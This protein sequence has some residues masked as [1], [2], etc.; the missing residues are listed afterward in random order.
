VRVRFGIAIAWLVAG[1][2]AACAP[3]LAAPAPGTA[4]VVGTVRLV[5]HEGAPSHPE[6][7]GGAYG[8]RRL[9]DVQ[10]VDYSKPGTSVVYL[11]LGTRPGGRA[12]IAV[13]DSVAGARFEPRF[14]VVGAGGEL[15]V[16]NRTHSEVVV[17]VPA[18]N[19]IER[20]AAGASLAVPPDRAGSL[21]LFLLGADA[22]ARVWVSPGP[23]VR[24]DANGRF[25]LS[26]LAPGRV[27]LRA[28]HPRLPSAAA[29][30]DLRA[31]E[32]ATVNFEIGVGRGE[33][34]HESHAH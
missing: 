3:D 31:G 27:T 6:M 2:L 14:A 17:S 32:T 28:W 13:E 29:E 5:P 15:T 25:A 11:D 22:P 8:D 4:S 26:G 21:D 24:P 30:L 7:Q 9:R 16:A 10:L 34:T 23:W 18:V 33:G 1:W 19:R 12:E 20:I